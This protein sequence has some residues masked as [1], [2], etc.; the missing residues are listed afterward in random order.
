MAAAPLGRNGNL[1]AMI[2]MRSSQF[3]TALAC[4]QS[5]NRPSSRESLVSP[6]LF[7]G[8]SQLTTGTAEFQRLLLAGA[9]P[10]HGVDQQ[11]LLHPAGSR[12]SRPPRTSIRWA[13]LVLARPS[14]KR[15][16]TF[17]PVAPAP[18]GPFPPDLLGQPCGASGSVMSDFYRRPREKAEVLP[19]KKRCL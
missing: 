4:L 6:D 5:L 18:W 9:S 12:Q 19:T 11:D 10:P 13:P 8:G 15:S 17:V 3:P 14:S 7:K 1:T 16:P 2:V